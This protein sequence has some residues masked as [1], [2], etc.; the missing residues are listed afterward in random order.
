M[1][2][3]KAW[4]AAAAAIFSALGITATSAGNYSTS[5]T[6]DVALPQAGTGST[7]TL[8][9][10][11]TA[12]ADFDTVFDCEGVILH[13]SVNGET[14]SS[15]TFWFG[16]RDGAEVDGHVTE[17]GSPLALP[18]QS[19]SGEFNGKY[20]FRNEF[21]GGNLNLDWPYSHGAKPVELALM[22]ET[23]VLV[24]PKFNGVSKIRRRT[25]NHTFVAGTI[26][27]ESATNSR[28]RMS[29]ITATCM[30]KPALPEAPDAKM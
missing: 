23:F 15:L 22:R 14:E 12:A 16:I 28:Q 11:E 2:K 26:R 7:V 17:I 20:D 29:F 1:N 27:F 13:P 8:V 24:G 18:A 21:T 4:A 6:N 30:P 9:S 3:P 10:R 19:I 5:Q 25:S